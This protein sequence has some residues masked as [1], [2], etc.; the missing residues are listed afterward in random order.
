VH[1]GLRR[2]RDPL[3]RLLKLESFLPRALSMPLWHW[4]GYYMREKLRFPR[5][6]TSDIAV[7]KRSLQRA[8]AVDYEEVRWV[9]VRT[10]GNLLRHARLSHPVRFALF[11][12]EDDHLVEPHVFAEL[13]E[14]LSQLNFSSAQVT[15]FPEGGHNIQKTQALR[16]AESLAA[17]L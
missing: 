12:A 3:N 17:W 6:T 5:S 7:I 14:A 1:R 15:V 4:F 9:V 8:D 11:Y 2:T 16:I 10:L 13:G